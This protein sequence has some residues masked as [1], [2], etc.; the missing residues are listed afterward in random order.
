MISHYETPQADEALSPEAIHSEVERILASDK[1][2]RSKRLRSL[3]RFT[4]TQTLQGNADTLKEYVIGTEVLK[5]PETYDPRSD[6]LVRVLASRLRAKLREYYRNGGMED[7][8]F[9]EFPKGRYVPV[10]QRREHFQ[11]RV[12]QKLRARKAYSAGRLLA[13]QLTEEA[14]SESAQHLCE[15]IE[16]DPSWALPHSALAG[17]YA[18]QAFMNYGRPRETWA[19]AKASAEVALQM[20]E[21]SSE[22]HLC[23]ALMEGLY[24]RRWKESDA[25]FHKAI[26][27]DSYS[28]VGHLWRA[29]AYLI[30]RG[31]VP[32]ARTEIARM[33]HMA[34]PHLRAPEF[35]ALYFSGEHQAVI[36]RREAD[37]TDAGQTPRWY[38]WMRSCALA[39]SGRLDA[40]ISALKDLQA[41]APRE[42]RVVSTLGYVYGVA[43]QA[44]HAQEMLNGL[45]QRREEGAWI[46]NYEMALIQTG[47]GNSQEALALLHESYRE[48]EPWLAFLAVD[49]RLSSLRAAPQFTSLIRK[50][51]PVDDRTQAMAG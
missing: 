32:E 41:S 14:L 8:L 16:A 33:R 48:R 44:D 2:A 3:L 7:P 20:D 22:A 42:T 17:V 26:E 34:P 30:P 50:V 51:F 38:E 29:L 11:S 18:S 5:K 19:Q 13:G 39:A 46:P 28:G 25:L 4:V 12:E 47:L 37:Q 40:A 15:A 45:R 49:P 35:L 21:M 36:S 1:F 9:I 23:L 31:Y 43:G 10:F 27:R 6:S 24:H